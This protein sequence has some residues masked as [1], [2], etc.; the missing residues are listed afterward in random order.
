MQ[1]MR[2]RL[3]REASGCLFILKEKRRSARHKTKQKAEK[4]AEP[5]TSR[6]LS[7][8]LLFSTPFCSPSC[9]H[10]PRPSNY[11][12]ERLRARKRRQSGR[13]RRRRRWRSAFGGVDGWEG[14]ITAFCPRLSSSDP[15][16]PRLTAPAPYGRT[17]S[18]LGADVGHV[19][20][21]KRRSEPDFRLTISNSAK[22]R[23]PLTREVT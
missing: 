13:R 19:L 1:Q 5:V 8:F 16:A 20:T 2:R 11:S 12:N 7:T 14:S 6:S 17:W 18:G 15:P 9:C 21:L 22:Y 3:Y 10:L 23:I 4:R